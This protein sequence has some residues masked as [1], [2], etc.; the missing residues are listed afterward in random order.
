MCEA[1][2]EVVRIVFGV[3]EAVA[4]DRP[5]AVVHCG[6]RSVFFGHGVNDYKFAGLNEEV[7][8]FYRGQKTEKWGE[9]QDFIRKLSPPL[10]SGLIMWDQ[11]SFT[12]T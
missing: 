1:G 6:S 4:A 3:R 2:S 12:R 7:S 11:P 8:G 9:L 10:E 5:T